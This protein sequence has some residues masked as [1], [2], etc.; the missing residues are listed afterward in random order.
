[1]STDQKNDCLENILKRPPEAQAVVKGSNDYPDI[2]GIVFFYQ[3]GCGV[4]VMAE[5]RGL[6]H[7]GDKCPADIFAFHIHEG[8]S[9]TG[10][11]EDP[12]AGAGGHYNPNGCPHP[13]HAGDLPPLFG[14]DGYAFMAVFTDRFSVAD[15]TGRTV[16]IHKSPDDFTTQ[17]SG[18]SGKKIACGKITVLATRNM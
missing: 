5:V 10:T 8:N 17:P 9:C 2:K 6:P 3:L 18:N 16:I 7:G 11:A 12:F 14:N 13:A 15:V 4:L 1:M